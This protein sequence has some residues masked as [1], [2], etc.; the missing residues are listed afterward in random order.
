MDIFE[1]GKALTDFWTL[2]GK[3]LLSGQENAYR[4]FTDNMS[5]MS[6]G[7]SGGLSMPSLQVESRG[8]G[9]PLGRLS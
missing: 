6:A 9:L 1:Y 7:S 3:A 4:T 5:K 8:S 2:G